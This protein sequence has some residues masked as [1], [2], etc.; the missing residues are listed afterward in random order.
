MS[1]D[2]TTL[3]MVPAGRRR[4]LRSEKIRTFAA[5][6]TLSKVKDER[7]AHRIRQDGLNFKVVS[8]DNQN[9]C[10]G[11]VNIS[12]PMENFTRSLET[13]L[14]QRQWN[15]GYH[16]AGQPSENDCSCSAISKA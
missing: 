10:L 7:S 9:E 11:R 1:G 4:F 2:E 13:I 8:A 5:L 14:T 12:L 15:P 16:S 6:G 3:T